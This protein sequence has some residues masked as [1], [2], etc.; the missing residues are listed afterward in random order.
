MDTTS[1]SPQ[2]QQQPKEQQP[3][4]VSVVGIGM[5]RT[6]TTTLK[7]AL[8]ILG[9]GDGYHLSVII[10]NP[11]HCNLWAEAALNPDSVDLGAILCGYGH[12]SDT[13]VLYFYEQLMHRFPHTKFI[14][15]RRDPEQWYRSISKTIM[16][17]EPETPELARMLQVLRGDSLTSKASALQHMREHEERV[18]R[19]IPA[20][21]LL[22]YQV[23]EGWE[24]LCTFLGRPKPAVAFPHVN[25]AASF[26]ETYN[27]YNV[28]T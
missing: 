7:T 20:D 24:P 28:V 12:A 8:E 19:T 11:E 16:N 5:P 9:L 23:T 4:F 6:G 17:G 13:P 25:D 15:T 18:L 27:V 22:V 21:R 10:N 26:H 14:L 3:Q 1:A 2:Q